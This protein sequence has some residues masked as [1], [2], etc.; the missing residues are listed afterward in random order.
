MSKRLPETV[1]Q[2]GNYYRLL[3]YFRRFLKHILTFREWLLVVHNLRCCH[4]KCSYG[5]GDDGVC[6]VGLNLENRDNVN[7][8]Y[9][10]FA[11]P[12]VRE[13]DYFIFYAI[14]LLKSTRMR[15]SLFF[16]FFFFMKLN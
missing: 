15:F 3:S 14:S 12:R 8:S 7:I 2:E 16:F 10:K 13:R 9:S 11:L 6:A 4:S 1:A 5:G